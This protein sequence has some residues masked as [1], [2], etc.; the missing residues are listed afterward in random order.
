MSE[1]QNF[2]TCFPDRC[3]SVLSAYYDIAKKDDREVTL[4]LNVAAAAFTVAYE[5]WR[6]TR[7]LVADAKNQ[8]SAEWKKFDDV[9]AESFMKGRFDPVG[10]W[11]LAQAQPKDSSKTPPW[12]EGK[13]E[14]KFPIVAS[15]SVFYV[16]DILRNAFA[17][18]NIRTFSGDNQINTLVFVVWARDSF[19]KD[20]KPR[21]D[22]SK[23]D[24][25][26]VS[27]NDFKGFLDKWLIF[28]KKL[29]VFNAT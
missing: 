22:K 21:W 15:I 12:M 26:A 6:D 8:F 11:E 4:M 7:G 23:N 17:H 16:L 13:L 29:R 10:E 28:L 19:D 20:D 9:L 3:Q 18:G 14:G 24:L 1:Y 25:L 5:G 2:L 27:V